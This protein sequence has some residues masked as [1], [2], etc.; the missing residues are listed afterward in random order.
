MNDRV[1]SWKDDIE[2]C[3]RDVNVEGL[4]VRTVLA[5]IHVESAGNPEARR[6]GSQFHGL[7]QM[8]HLAGLDVGMED[9]GVLTTNQL[10]GNGIAAISAFIAYVE[11]YEARLVTGK[12]ASRSIA[13]LWKG[14]PGTAAYI[15]D[16]L[17]TDTDIVFKE[18]VAAAQ[19]AKKVKNLGAYLRRFD[20]AYSDYERA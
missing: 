19:A 6:V 16:T 4:D 14:G 10:L 11:R 20:E 3:L 2:V 13:T 18:A 7:L 9:M 1:L 15:R 17:D 5:L 8:G 12:N